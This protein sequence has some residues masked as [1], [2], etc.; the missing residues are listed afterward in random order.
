MNTA[1]ERPVWSRRRCLFCHWQVFDAV[2]YQPLRF[3]D[4][5]WE[6]ITPGGK[7]FIRRMLCKDPK[8]RATVGELL[9]H[10]WLRLG[11]GGTAAGSSGGGAAATSVGDAPSS[12][13]AAQP[14]GR[15]ARA[16]V[17]DAVVS[18]LRRFAAMSTFKKEARR[19]LAKMLPEEEV[20]GLRSLFCDMDADHDG[21]V[22]ARELYDA[23]R[24]RGV[25]ILWEQAKVR[26]RIPL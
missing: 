3:D 6:F 15:A 24:A 14:A 25:R 11:G 21:R 2:T 12:G 13:A 20:A 4:P 17:P 18:R 23:L 9:K 8:Q 1:D 5:T 19:V 7:D 26:A 22:T 16:R 10:P